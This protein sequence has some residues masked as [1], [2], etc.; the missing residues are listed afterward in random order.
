METVLYGVNIGRL[1]LGCLYKNLG[2]ALLDFPGSS[3]PHPSA[4]VVVGLTK[5]GAVWPED[6]KKF[7]F[8]V[9]WY[10]WQ[11]VCVPVLQDDSV[12]VRTLTGS[13]RN[14]SNVA[15]L[16][17]DHA[18]L[19]EK[20]EAALIA[21]FRELGIF[22]EAEAEETEPEGATGEPGGEP[23]G[24]PIIRGGDDVRWPEGHLRLTYPLVD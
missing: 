18:V 4:Q 24:E 16:D 6:S 14:A 20:I 23:D 19:L 2:R 3:T 10:I 8:Q 17:S 13:L 1:A 7:P 22:P 9:G 5:Q 15:L 11:E 12:M 21:R